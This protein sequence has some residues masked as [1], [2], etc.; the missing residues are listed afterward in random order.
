MILI[1][2]LDKLGLLM[3]AEFAIHRLDVVLDGVWREVEPFGNFFL[4]GSIVHKLH[5]SDFSLRQLR[6]ELRHTD[7]TIELAFS[8]QRTLDLLEVEG[9]RAINVNLCRVEFA[10]V[11]FTESPYNE[12]LIARHVD[13]TLLVFLFKGT[14]RFRVVLSYSL[15]KALNQFRVLF[16]DNLVTAIGSPAP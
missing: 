14:V 12:V 5:H 10:E 4:T 8:T 7:D 13:G 1:R 6:V 15:Q 16:S 11:T 9:S 3:D 2:I